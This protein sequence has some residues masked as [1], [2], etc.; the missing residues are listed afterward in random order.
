MDKVEYLMKNY[1]DVKLKLAL[2]TDSLLN[3]KEITEESVIQSLV[4]EKPQGER[5][6]TTP[7]YSR[8]ED[9]ALSF[10]EKFIKENREY[11][12]GLMSC[13]YFLKTELDFFDHVLGLLGDDLKELA[14][15]MVCHNMTWEELEK[16]YCISHSALAYRR[17]KI[18]SQLRQ[19]YDWMNRSLMIEEESFEIP[20]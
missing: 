20:R 5:V 3:Y 9:I 4:F 18:I 2:V 7:T 13:Y 16:K 1:S 15:D 17:R 11:W 8:A 6:V 19:C 12:E 14:Q 10:R